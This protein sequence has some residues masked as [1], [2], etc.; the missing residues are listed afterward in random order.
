MNPD[1]IREFLRRQPF[2]P[3][4][5]RMSNG[6]VHEVRHPEC[7]IVMKTK[8]ILG[9]PEE[10]RAVHCVLIHVNTIEPLQAA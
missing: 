10:N 7:A 3:F 8:V 2:E 5:I 6:E 4:A 1:T 9:Y